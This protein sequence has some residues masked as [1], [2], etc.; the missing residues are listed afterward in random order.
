M[1]SPGKKKRYKIEACIQTMR[2]HNTIMILVSKVGKVCERES[3]GSEKK[4]KSW[5]YLVRHDGGSDNFFIREE[6]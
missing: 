5:E 1:Y 6:P 3:I 4:N 2:M